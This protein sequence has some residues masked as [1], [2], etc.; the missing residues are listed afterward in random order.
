[1]VNIKANAVPSKIAS[2]A[3]P[4]RLALPENWFR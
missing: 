3:T 1:M 2:P 4:R